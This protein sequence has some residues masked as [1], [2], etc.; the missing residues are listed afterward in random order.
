MGADR[1]PQASNWQLGELSMTGLGLGPARIH[2]FLEQF[3][4]SD[5][6]VSVVVGDPD[7]RNLRFA[8]L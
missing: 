3:V 5:P 7:E 1:L 8:G 2:Q 6:D 4:F